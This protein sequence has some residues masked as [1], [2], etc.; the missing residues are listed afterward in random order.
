M[1]RRTTALRPPVTLKRVAQLAGVS[2]PTASTV[3]NGAGGNT[4]VSDTTRERILEAAR[5]LDYH[6]NHHARSLKRGRSGAIGL[7]L[8]PP[9]T[10]STQGWLTTIARGAEHRARELGVDLIVI[11]ATPEIGAL[12]RGIDRAS[13]GRVDALLTF[14]GK[15]SL[16]AFDP[17]RLRVPL[18][19]LWDDRYRTGLPTVVVDEGPAIQELIEHLRGLGHRRALYLGIAGDPESA[20]RG[21]RLRA[22]A[23]SAVEFEAAAIA[24][25]PGGGRDLAKA[26]AHFRRQALPL[27]ESCARHSA[28]VCYHDL[29]ALG[30]QQALWEGDPAAARR[31]A[32]IGFDDLYA[33]FGHPALSSVD[34][35]LAEV[36]ARGVDL[37][38][39]LARA[40]RIESAPVSARLITRESSRGAG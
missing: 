36:G 27:V 19:L 18:V 35:G 32:L 5:E 29:V 40:Q 31:L 23:G 37:A 28:V 8:D 4:V 33:R 26:I 20:A 30:L 1:A 34:L 16:A 3:L 22:I 24:P 21:E 38:L 13:D 25:D 6:P 2:V 12:D 9:Q 17:K 11:G 39:A 14:G 15:P 10:G 7:L